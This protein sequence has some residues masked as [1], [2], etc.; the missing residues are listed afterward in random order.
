M[1][2]KEVAAFFGVHQATVAR[3]VH[4]GTLRPLKQFPGLRGARIFHRDEVA[5]VAAERNLAP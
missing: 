4:D 5:R 3:M 2:T 1:T